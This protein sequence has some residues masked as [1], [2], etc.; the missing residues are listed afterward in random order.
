[1][2]VDEDNNFVST[3]VKLKKLIKKTNSIV[4]KK[5]VGIKA[6]EL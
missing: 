6:R 3:R 2:S 4:N 5:H 1:M